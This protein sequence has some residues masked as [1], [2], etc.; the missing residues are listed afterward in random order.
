MLPT[1]CDV[2]KC[3]L[4]PQ[5]FVSS[6]ENEQL[7]LLWDKND[8]IGN[9]HVWSNGGGNADGLHLV[10]HSLF[11]GRHSMLHSIWESNICFI[12]RIEIR[13]VARIFR[14]DSLED[15]NSIVTSFLLPRHFMLP[16][17]RPF[18]WFHEQ[19]HGA[20]CL[21]TWTKSA[22]FLWRWSVFENCT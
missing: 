11:M 3:F 16:R 22:I 13:K 4:L 10:L 1:V 17:E 19:K 7:P 2:Q 5:F 21:Y 15:E 9:W 20:W 18:S 14:T 8:I 6:P 12:P